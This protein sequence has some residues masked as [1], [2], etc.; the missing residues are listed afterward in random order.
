MPHASARMS[1][2]PGD[3]CYKKPVLD[4]GDA[5]NLNVCDGVS[6]IGLEPTRQF[7]EPQSFKS[8]DEAEEFLASTKP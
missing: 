8:R 1:N 3:R 6:P 2:P 5:L 7:A 4:F